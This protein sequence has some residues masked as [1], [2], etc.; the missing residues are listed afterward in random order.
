MSKLYITVHY[1]TISYLLAKTYP[2]SYEGFQEWTV[3]TDEDL[4]NTEYIPT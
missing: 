2:K 1:S 3:F 4:K